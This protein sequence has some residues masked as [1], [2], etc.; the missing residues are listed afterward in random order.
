MDESLPLQNGASR[1]PPKEPEDVDAFVP[2]CRRLGLFINSYRKENDDIRFIS[3]SPSSRESNEC[4]ARFLVTSLLHNRGSDFRE[5]WRKS[6]FRDDC[7][8]LREFKRGCLSAMNFRRT[9]IGSVEGGNLSLKC[10]VIIAALPL[11]EP[12][13]GGRN[14]VARRRA[15]IRHPFR[16][17]RRGKFSTCYH[18]FVHIQ[19]GCG[20]VT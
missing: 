2:F 14:L 20:A 17:I 6:I 13:G 16:L 19:M 9:R 4:I 8:S 5:T 10:D 1:F 12:D 18:G 3:S 11:R 15:V 7:I